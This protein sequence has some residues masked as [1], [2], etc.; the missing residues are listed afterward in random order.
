MPPDDPLG[1]SGPTLDKFLQVNTHLG[2]PPPPCPYA[3]KCT[4]GNKCKFQHPERGTMP[5]K[6]VTERLVEHAQ[7]QLQ[8]RARDSS[9]GQ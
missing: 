6:T 1:R 3:K 9:P 5:H 7:R 2:E 8:A 4:Y